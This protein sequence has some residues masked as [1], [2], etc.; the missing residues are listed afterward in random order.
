MNYLC[1]NCR[2]S[3]YVTD[4]DGHLDVCDKCWG[5]GYI[6]A[7]EE[8]KPKVE[9][10]EKQI[11]RNS[12]YVMLA[13]TASSWGLIVLF[14]LYITFSIYYFFVLFIGPYYLGLLGSSLYVRYKN[15][16]RLKAGE[17]SNSHGH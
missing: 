4:P 15:K 7:R 1:E 14:S 13:I 17:A 6:V 2:G 8:P 3:G 10:P 12:M 5:L 9:G 11:K 16:K